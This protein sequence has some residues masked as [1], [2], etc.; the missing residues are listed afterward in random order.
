M[1]GNR[2]KFIKQ[3]LALTACSAAAVSGLTVSRQAAA[4]LAI[5]K[6]AASLLEATL[7]E[8]FHGE[9]ITATEKI[10]IQIPKI[11]ENGAVVPITITSSLSHVSTVFILVEKNPLPLSAKFTLS[12][13][14]EPF[15]S[16]RLKMA[17]TS[18]VIVIAKTNEGLY[19]GRE[20]VKVTIGGCGG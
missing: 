16:A 2:R 17:E 6:P 19:S 13:E 8:L 7:K 11:A 9:V 1:P 20:T 4:G 14:L 3:T 12:P 5:V 10:V 15:L 18:D